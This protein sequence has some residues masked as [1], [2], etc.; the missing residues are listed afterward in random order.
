MSARDTA[1]AL[2][3]FL[4]T[5][6]A[7]AGVSGH[8]FVGYD[9]PIYVTDNQIVQR[10]L[11]GEGLR[12][13][14]TATHASNWH[15]LTWLTHM[16]DVQLFG[17]DAG[18]HHL[19]SVALHAV[20]A[21]LLFLFLRTTTRR[22]WPSFLAA[23]LFAWHPLRV[24]SVAWVAER[25]DVLAGL[26]WML[27]LSAWVRY[28]R[29]PAAGTYLVVLA[30]FALGL[31]AKPML[32]TL[33][34][35]LLLLDHWPLRRAERGLGR[36]VREKLPLFALAALS[37]VV[38][39]IVQRRGGAV[40]PLDEIDLALRAQNA[41][42]ALGTYLLQT[43]WPAGLACFY[44]HPALVADEPRTAL[45][46]PA[47]ASGVVLV[48]LAVL[49]VRAA[50]RRPY[51][52]VGLLWTLG[53]LVPVIGLVQVGLQS[54]ADRYTYLPL[55]GV[56]LA[57]AFGTA[58]LARARPGRPA[59]RRGVVGVAAAALA[60]CLALTLR[61]V[62]TWRD[63]FALWERAL[64]VTDR[65]W[66][67]HAN[68]GQVLVDQE[69]YERAVDELR[70]AVLVLPH[71]TDGHNNLGLAL[72][73]AGRPAEAEA[74]LE[75][76][77]VIDPDHPEARNNLGIAKLRLER[78]EEALREFRGAVERAPEY[79]SALVNLGLLLSQ[80]GADAESV[81][82]LQRAWELEPGLVAAGQ[83]LAWLLA[84]S[85]DDAVRDGARAVRVVAECL[86]ASA[87]PSPGLL[88]TAAAAYAAA[89]RF[90]EA[91]RAQRAALARVPPAARAEARE[92]LRL[93]ENGRA[94]GKTP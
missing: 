65:N 3:L 77:L 16:L 71:Y 20:N 82:H 92:R 55:I 78:P 49:A 40:A 88:E 33:P 74:S 67:A 27:T 61:Q 91:L 25:K 70:A 83:G 51:L 11:T 6:A 69:E 15:P 59:W 9:D 44:P 19:V 57:L 39:L 66:I 48:V 13:A 35:V 34:F 53:T 89:D 38:T 87:V 76:A 68:L 42:A 85:R 4:G 32:V 7:Y 81:R 10:G 31:L 12:W 94:Y 63:S 18:R 30:S 28:A 22:T 37:C 52:L 41:L 90:P 24:E 47:L 75:R 60:A 21:L 1:L 23:A 2:A 72:L 86:A 80:T 93:Y 5:L 36:L 8:D 46:L 14:F 79:T 58:E 54:H 56:A 73:H 62:E 43:V 26:F 64:A 29:R 84:T 45:L 17:L 50:R